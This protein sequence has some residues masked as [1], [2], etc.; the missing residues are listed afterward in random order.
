MRPPERSMGI[1]LIARKNAAIARPLSVLQN[2]GLMLRAGSAVVGLWNEAFDLDGKPPGD[3]TT[4]P[5]V[6]RVLKADNS[7]TEARKG[8]TP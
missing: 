7:A 1:W 3:G 2:S 8:G 5:G 4:V 6:Q